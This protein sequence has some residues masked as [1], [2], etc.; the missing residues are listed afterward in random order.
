MLALVLLAMTA[1]SRPA[2][3]F[4]GDS[5]AG[6]FVGTTTYGVEGYS[7]YGAS[8]GGSYG[9]EYATNRL[10]TLGATFASTSGTTTDTSGTLYNLSASSAEFKAGLLAYFNSERS[11][12]RPYLGAGLSVLSY[13]L[14]FPGTTVGKTDGTG[15]GAYGEVGLEI[16]L[17]RHFTLIPQFG[18]QAHT[19]K[20]EAGASTGLLSG[21]L[22]FTLRITD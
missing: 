18:L 7:T 17:T 5:Y 10:W 4:Q 20:T 16:R 21:G 9:Y 3:A 14:D 22:V 11:A 15:P 12:F 6:L 1:G 19:I 8:F 2:W 13:K